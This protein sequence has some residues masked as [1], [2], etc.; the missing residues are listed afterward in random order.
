[1]TTRPFTAQQPRAH[2]V[3]KPRSERMCLSYIQRIHDVPQIG[4]GQILKVRSPSLLA[5]AIASAVPILVPPLNVIGKTRFSR[6][7]SCVPEMP[8]RRTA[9]QYIARQRTRL[10]NTPAL[11]ESIKNLVE[12]LP[13][14]M[15][16]AEQRA[17]RRL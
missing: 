4:V 2:R 14:R 12:A 15:R 11:P 16:R 17:Q 10:M 1:M 8:G 3:R 5:A 7:R 13:I 6:P 9:A